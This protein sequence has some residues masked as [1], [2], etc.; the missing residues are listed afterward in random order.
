MGLRLVPGTGRAARVVRARR[1]A[2]VVSRARTRAA[3]PRL[4]RLYDDWPFFRSVIDHARLAVQR[5]DMALAR[6]YA[7]LAAEPGDA[8]RW[9]SIEAEFDRTSRALD[10]LPTGASTTVAGRAE[11]EAVARS[12]AL[13]VPYVD[14]LSVLQLE[15]L[16][17]LRQREAADPSTLAAGDPAADRA[18]D[19]RPL[20]RAPGDRLRLAAART[21]P[22][23]AEHV[24]GWEVDMARRILFS[25]AAIVRGVSVG[26]GPRPRHRRRCP[27]QRAP[28]NHW[29]P[30]RPRPTKPVTLPRQVDVPLNG[31]CEQENV[32]CFGKL[33]AGKV[34]TTKVFTPAMSF[35]VPT[36][37]WVNPGETGGDFA[38]FSTRDIGDEII[39]FRDVKRST[40]PSERRSPTSPT[41]SSPTTPDRHA[42]R[43]GEDRRA[44]RRRAG[45]SRRP[46]RH[47]HGPRLPGPGLRLLLRGDDPDPNDPYQ[48]HWD[49][50]SPEPRPNACTSWTAGHGDRD[51]RR[52]DRR[53]DVRRDD[54]GRS[55]R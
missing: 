33:E 21:I 1:R 3:R 54:A 34:Y 46:R 23:S 11:A 51:L 55:T 5:A 18:H 25:F 7:A 35:A 14:T 12:A 44:D 24:S 52:F 19:Q 41:G 37:D 30:P 16:R 53:P 27:R 36:S 38:L 22:P 29:P 20:R 10:R 31:T 2:G 47:Q 48:W 50:S 28:R 39:F 6:G 26:W 8:E 42:I 4:A 45:H 32:S 40:Q 17:V 13:R 43:T 15:L 9:A 49:W